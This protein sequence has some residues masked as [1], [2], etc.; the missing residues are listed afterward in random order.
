[1]GIAKTLN[2]TKSD[3]IWILYYKFFIWD[4]T[5]SNK[6]TRVIYFETKEE[7]LKFK[8][9]LLKMEISL[10]SINFFKKEIYIPFEF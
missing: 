5:I 8:K 10:F 6:F 7:T 9:K 3:F 1:M 2:S 4:F